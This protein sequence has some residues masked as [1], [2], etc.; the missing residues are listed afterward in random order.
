MDS[1]GKIA[2]IFLVVLLLFLAPLLLMEERKDLMLENYVLAKT[3]YLVEHIRS[4]GYLSPR[5][6]QQYQQELNGTGMIYEIE[7]EHE[8][9]VYYPEEQSER[10]IKHYKNIYEDD[11]LFT[12]LEQNRTYQ[13]GRGD[14]FFMKVTSKSKSMASKLRSYFFI[15]KSELPAIQVELGG[16]IRDEI[17]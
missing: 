4:N 17:S 11:I 1:V 16:R 8:R 2:S 15:S 5:M 7:M 12:V 14:F 6:Y 9:A 13:M 10:L 3:D